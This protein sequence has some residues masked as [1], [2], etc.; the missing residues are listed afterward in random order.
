MNAEF[1]WW[2]LIVGLVIGGGLVWL[3]VADSSRREAEIADEELPTEAAWLSAALRDAGRDVPPEVA[4]EMLRL[5]RAY[6]AAPPPDEAAEPTVPAEHPDP[7]D[8][9]AV[10]RAGPVQHADTER[11]G[12]REPGSQL[13]RSNPGQPPVGTTSARRPD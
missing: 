3:V 10:R 12:Y 9:V 7:A 4:E 6:L 5:H 2:L 8:A 1:N 11:S 13:T